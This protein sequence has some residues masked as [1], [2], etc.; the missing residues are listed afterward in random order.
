MRQ[1]TLLFILSVSACSYKKPQ[2]ETLRGD[3]FGL[4]ASDTMSLF[5]ADI[6]STEFQELNAAFSPEGDIFMWTIADPMR[7][8]Y[9]IMQYQRNDD[10]WEGPQIAS[11]SGKYSDADPIF[12][13]DGKRVY[14]ISKRP[15]QD[16][17]EEKPDFD[18]WYVE[19]NGFD[20]S[21]PVHMGAPINSELNEY[22][23]SVTSDGTLVYSSSYEGGFGGNDI[24]FA[25]PTDDGY[26]V[27]NAG[28][29]INSQF[30]EG[31]PYISADGNMLIFSAWGRPDSL[32][33]GDLYISYKKDGQW[34]QAQNMGPQFNSTANE[35]CPIV[36]PD[37]AYFFLTS[38]RAPTFVSPQEPMSYEQYSNRLKGL[39][40]GMGNVYWVN[41]KTL[42]QFKQ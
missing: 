19:R 13:P 42:E 1:L 32:G 9:T 5:A 30:S 17:L 20:W 38:Y 22:Y 31:D 6:V 24:Y 33:S 26:Q 12:S 37:G 40:N 4:T 28:E 35:Y 23:V 3:Y 15:I 41:S 10:V 21:E 34:S 16:G 39:N 7:T 2:S 29:A 36:S 8:Y 11:F 25:T 18:I 14:F 27:S